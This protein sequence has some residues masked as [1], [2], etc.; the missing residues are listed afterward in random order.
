VLIDWE[1]A[2]I[3]D[4]ML[5]L[6]NWATFHPERRWPVFFEAASEQGPYAQRSEMRALFWLYYLRVALAKTVHRIRFG[7]TDKPGRPP[8]SMRIQRALKGLH[9][10]ESP[11]LITGGINA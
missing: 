2:C 8:A 3:G 11:P 1:D 6:A 10:H 7:V 4:P 5:D 9:E